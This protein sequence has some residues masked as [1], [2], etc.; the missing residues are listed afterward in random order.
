M[1]I[2]TLPGL[3]PRLP[4]SQPLNQMSGVRIPVRSS[5]AIILD[6]FAQSQDR[7]KCVASCGTSNSRRQFQRWNLE[8]ALPVVCTSHR[9]SSPRTAAV[10]S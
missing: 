3:E 8:R 6:E 9:V 1:M 4:D 2:G 5:T 7:E 10:T